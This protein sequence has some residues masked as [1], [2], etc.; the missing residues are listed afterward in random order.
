MTNVMNKPVFSGLLGSFLLVVTTNGFADSGMDKD[1][2]KRIYEAT[3]QEVALE[4]SDHKNGDRYNANHKFTNYEVTG[5]YQVKNTENLEMKTDG[6]NHSGCKSMPRCE[7]MEPKFLM[8]GGKAVLGAEYPHPEN[9]NDIAC[10]SCV[11]L[12]GNFSDKWVGY[13]VI[14]YTNKSGLRTVEQWIDPDGL[15]L[16]G[17]P[18]NNWKL[19]LKETNEGQIIPNPERELPMEDR[20]LEA[21]IRCNNGKKTQMKYG[22]VAEIVAQ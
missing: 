20:G 3:G 1:G 14:A 16:K 2:I 10:E 6:P 11:E 19:T 17:K 9:H 21:E 7:W 15:D 22:K 4:F 5:Y 12:G 13:K 8:D 18:A